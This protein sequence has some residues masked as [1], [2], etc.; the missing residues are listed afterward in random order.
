[1][2]DE[3]NSD[4]TTAAGASGSLPTGGAGLGLPAALA[5]LGGLGNAAVGLLMTPEMPP[6]LA[7]WPLRADI[8]GWIADG[9]WG[10][11][12][13]VAAA[14]LLLTATLLGGAGALLAWRRLD[15]VQADAAGAQLE[16][17]LS[18]RVASMR[19]LAVS[20]LLTLTALVTPPLYSSDASLYAYY[21][22][23]QAVHGE[24]PYRL[25]GRAFARTCALPDAP[26][27]VATPGRPCRADA[28]C[29]PPSRC[30][31]D[32][33]VPTQAWLEVRAAYG[34]L[35]L[36]LFRVAYVEALPPAANAWILRALAGLAL[37]AAVLALGRRRGPGAAALLGFSPLAWQ[38]AGNGGHLEAAVCLLLIA[39][40]PRTETTPSSGLGWR[41]GALAGLLGLLKL[42]L[43]VLTLPMAWAAWRGADPGLG[44]S[45]WRPLLATALPAV[46]LLGLGYA[47]YWC[48]P[49][50]FHGLLEVGGTTIRT[51]LDLIRRLQLLA[52]GDAELAVARALFALAAAALALRLLIRRPAAIVDNALGVWLLL[53]ALGSGIFH[54]W[55]ALPGLLLCAMAAGP[56]RLGGKANAALWLGLASPA[57]VPMAFL[58]LGSGAFAW[59]GVLWPTALLWL[60]VLGF[61]VRGRAV[62][63][64]R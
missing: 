51:P 15:A 57:V 30:L 19:V 49:H 25:P 53:V 16:G 11:E 7:D 40:L 43:A 24:N 46:A 23:I 22:K 35:A 55:Y 62:D 27:R 48:A 42:P 1:M 38:S 8:Q 10:A 61:L 32:P 31:V 21:G 54:P 44:T 41:A 56:T 50:P 60:P 33:F 6:L 58:L 28:H 17:A 3:A 18:G 5:L 13:Q 20:A 4:V 2:A 36:W 29:P 26:H 64:G 37:L 34:P 52:G 59:P 12:A 14:L 47:A 9:G 45:R 63:S 39:L